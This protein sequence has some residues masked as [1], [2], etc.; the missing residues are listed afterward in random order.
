MQARLSSLDASDPDSLRALMD[1][2]EGLFGT[3]L[4]DEQRLKLARIQ[5]FM[6]AAEG[7]ADHVMHAI[8]RELLPSYARIDEALRRYREE[9]ASD[10]V[11]ERLLGVEMKRERYEAG[12]A[13]CDEV[14]EQT[15]EA[16]LARMWESA[17][18]MP[19]LPE[20]DEPVLWLARTV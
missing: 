15:D 18:A 1:G 7:Y 11:F 14:V 16:T 17:E 3:E 20:V 13:F 12:R 2:E 4:D 10:P 5:A 9:D 19:S 6:A 8:G